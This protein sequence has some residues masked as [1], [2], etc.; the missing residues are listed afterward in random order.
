MYWE[1]TSTCIHVLKEP[2]FTCTAVEKVIFFDLK[3]M[4]LFNKQENECV[5]R[6]K[7]MYLFFYQP[8]FDVFFHYQQSE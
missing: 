6:A 2:R 7:H 1:Y 8:S 5:E 3:F 4:G